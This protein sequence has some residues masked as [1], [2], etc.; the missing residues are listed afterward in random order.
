VTRTTCYVCSA[1]AAVALGS[2]ARVEP[3]Q[4][5]QGH[6][7]GVYS[8]TFGPDGAVRFPPDG[9]QIASAGRH[10]TVRLWYAATG[11]PGPVLEGHNQTVYCL[12]FSPDGK[13]LSSGSG[14]R[15]I[16]LWDTS[17]GR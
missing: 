13:T 3:P 2:P 9:K 14:D 12:A 6:R 5:L 8:V 16:R 17:R 11:R 1:L 4:V 10:K 15:T 7:S